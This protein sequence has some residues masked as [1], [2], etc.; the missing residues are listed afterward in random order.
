MRLAQRPRCISKQ[1]AHSDRL[2]SS[3]RRGRG[4]GT[5]G[6]GL[7]RDRPGLFFRGIGTYDSCVN[8][9]AAL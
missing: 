9:Q 7:R 8:S 6:N 1:P 2:V 4:L 5:C 3:T